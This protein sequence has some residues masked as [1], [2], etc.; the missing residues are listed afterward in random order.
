M[1]PNIGYDLQA[2]QMGGGGTQGLVGTASASGATSLTGSSETPGT[3][4]ASNDRVGQ[5]IVAGSAA[6]NLC[7]GE[8]TANTSGTT[9]VYTVTR[10]NAFGTP[11]GSV[12]S[13]PATTAP[14]AIVAG[15]PPAQ[16]LGL[17]ANNASENAS[18]TTLTGE[19]VTASGGLVRALWTAWAHTAGQSQYQQTWVFTANG[20]DSLPVTIAKVMEFTS[21]VGGRALFEKLLSA[22][23]TLS[24]SGDQLTVSLTVSE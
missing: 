12:A 19:I 2:G 9:P 8:I 10:W 22:T 24:Q 18:D 16:F 5:I 4:H 17:S 3:S 15:A 21:L 11:G 6:A 14:Y 23:A 13:T 7:W 20:S 1:K